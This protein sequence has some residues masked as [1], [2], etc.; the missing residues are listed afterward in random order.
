[1]KAK[2]TERAPIE[3]PASFKDMNPSS[4]YLRW[5]FYEDADREIVKSL[6]EEVDYH[7]IFGFRMSSSNNVAN[8]G[9]VTVASQARV[10]AQE[11][12]LTIRAWDY[13]HVDILHSR[14][15]VARMKLLLDD[16]F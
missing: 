4:D 5:M 3:L 8:D 12:A 6:R 1:V 14:E 13:G 9:S 11:Q 10:E 7:M 16:R 15:A 2:G